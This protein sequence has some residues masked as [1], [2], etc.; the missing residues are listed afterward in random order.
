MDN[1]INLVY[2]ASER[3][4]VWERESGKQIKLVFYVILFGSILITQQQQRWV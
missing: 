2:S 4:G 3:G 1:I